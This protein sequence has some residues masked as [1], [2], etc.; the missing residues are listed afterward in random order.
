MLKAEEGNVDEVRRIL[1]ELKNI[2]IDTCNKKGYTALALAVK[3]GHFD[4]V[5]FLID[6]GANPDLKN[7]V[8][9][10]IILKY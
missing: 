1:T 4:V 5:K 10:S 2:D 7:N 6:C 9:I 3:A 8:Y